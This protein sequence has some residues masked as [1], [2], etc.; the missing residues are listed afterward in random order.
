VFLYY[1]AVFVIGAYVGV[2]LTNS[3][4]V[5]F[6]LTPVSGLALL[7]GAVIG[8][9]VLLSLSFEFLVLLS[10]IVG[11]QMLSL[12][13]GLDAV[14]TL[15]FAIAGIII[16]FGLMRSFNYDFR[17]RPRRRLFPRLA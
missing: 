11:A 12:G 4:A 14:W 5:A 15:I 9:I 8:G 6:S 16:Q 13:L 3:A 10:S 17:R 7:I 1:L 2:L